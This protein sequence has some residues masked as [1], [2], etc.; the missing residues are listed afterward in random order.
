MNQ[1]A[2]DTHENWLDPDDL[3]AARRW[4]PILYVNAVPIHVDGAGVATSVG[5]LLRST[6]DGEIH[7]ELVGGRVLHHER[8][9]DALL[10]HIEKDLGALALPQIPASPLPFTV[11]EFFPTPGITPYHDPRQHAVAL[12]FIVPV[13]GDC[14]PRQ[15]ALDIIWLAPSDAA[16][17]TVQKEMLGGHGILLRQALAHLGFPPASPE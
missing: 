1:T 4:V 13:T 10:R 6:P 2:V 15:D 14:A 8:I 3:A 7:R 17:D 9:R 5:L 16:A 11:A 12:A